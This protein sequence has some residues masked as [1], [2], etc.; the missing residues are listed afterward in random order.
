MLL[1]VGAAEQKAQRWNIMFYHESVGMLMLA[2][3]VP[4]LATRLLTRAPNPIPEPQWQLLAAKVSHAALYGGAE[5]LT[6]QSVA[7]HTAHRTSSPRLS[8]AIP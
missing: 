1:L 5:F 2:M 7:P 3:L 8:L 4:R 6:R